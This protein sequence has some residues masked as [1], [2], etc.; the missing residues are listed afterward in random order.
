MKNSRMMH[1]YANSEREAVVE[2]ENPHA[3]I[4][5]M[6]DELLRSMNIFAENLDAQTSDLE[7]RNKHMARSLTIIYELQTCLNME[8]GGEIAENLFR[9][10]EY[11]RQQILLNTQSVERTPLAAA[12]RP[13]ADIRD[14]WQMVKDPRARG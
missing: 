8:K 11:A 13:L 7:L 2:S 14:A 6:Y 1:A 4:A 12:I 10:Y 9:L 3:L 5:I